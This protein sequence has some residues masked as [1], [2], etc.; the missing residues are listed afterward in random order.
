MNE[1]GNFWGLNSFWTLGKSKPV[2]VKRAKPVLTIVGS[3]PKPKRFTPTPAFMIP[4]E[5]A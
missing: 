2:G 4:K 3:E 1:R 5:P